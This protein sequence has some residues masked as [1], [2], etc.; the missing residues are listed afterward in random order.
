ME[1]SSQKSPPSQAASARMIAD[2]LRRHDAKMI[3]A[4]LDALL[5]KRRAE[6]LAWA[7]SFVKVGGV[8]FRGSIEQL[9]ML[10]AH[11]PMPRVGEHLAFERDVAATRKRVGAP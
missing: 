5:E 10:H 9:S 11:S 2:A 3:G 6:L 8:D 1:R 4:A 7:R